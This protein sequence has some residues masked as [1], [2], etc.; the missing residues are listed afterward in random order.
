MR[1]L[2]LFRHGKSDW[3]TDTEG[4]DLRRPLSQRGRR[5]ARTMGRFLALAGEV[6]DSAITSPALRATET[7]RLAKAAGGWSC[8]ELS[9]EGLSG[10]VSAVLEEIRAAPAVAEVLLI[11]GHEPTSSHLAEFLIGGGSL[12]LP[13]G[14][15][16]RIDLNVA[17][18][19]NA[20]IGS[21]QL[22]W[23]VPPRLFPKRSFDFA[24]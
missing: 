10:D 14:A 8:P 18:W 5:A 19:T 17:D 4:E 13:T 22:A 6:P 1:S 12:R 23:L 2:I 9:R 15:L 3:Q 16:A 7:L 11:V 20:G 24:D 21:G